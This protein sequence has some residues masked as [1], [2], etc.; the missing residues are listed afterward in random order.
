MN[1]LVLNVL[2]KKDCYDYEIVKLIREI[3]Y[4]SLK[5]REGILYPNIHYMLK[6]SL[7]SKDEI[8]N[9]R[10]GVYYHIESQDIEYV[11]HTIIEFGKN[12]QDVFNIITYGEEGRKEE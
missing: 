8:Y 12:I 5:V 9:K 10:M 4:G 3:Y 1:M 6:K 7:I 2:K 11:E